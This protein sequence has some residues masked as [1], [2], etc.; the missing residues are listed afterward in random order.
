M[1]RGNSD[2]EGEPVML[3]RT[4]A[5]IKS[6][7]RDISMRIKEVESLLNIRSLLMDMLTAAQKQDPKKWI[8]EIEEV[9]KEA[10]EAL[11]ELRAL[12]DELDELF[13]EWREA[14][15]ASGI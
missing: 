13:C 15:C 12:K 2:Y 4:P 1:Y 8:P 9:V 11:E 6:D 3:Y 7:I 5:E 14:K 10:G